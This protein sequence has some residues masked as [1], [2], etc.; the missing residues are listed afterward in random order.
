MPARAKRPLAYTARTAEDAGPGGE[1]ADRAT[2]GDRLRQA[3]RTRAF[4]PAAAELVAAPAVPAEPSPLRTTAGEDATPTPPTGCPSLSQSHR[5]D[6]TP[7]PSPHPRP[8]T[9]PRTPSFRAP[10][11]GRRNCRA[12]PPTSG[13]NCQARQRPRPTPPAHLDQHGGRRPVLVRARQPVDPEPSPLSD[14]LNS[15]PGVSC[16]RSARCQRA[17]D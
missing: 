17:A 13:P 2:P 1:G 5:M 11:T 15:V 3:E 6:L 16:H 10:R 7:N 9:S 4:R 8:R 14:E 12:R